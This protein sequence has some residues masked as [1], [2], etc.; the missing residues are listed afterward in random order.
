MPNKDKWCE[1]VGWF[2]FVLIVSAYLLIT[3][4][5]VEVSSIA[6]HMMN[7]VGA[8]CMIVNA[9]HKG[10]RPLLWLNIVWALVAIVGLLQLGRA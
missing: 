2:G 5:L 7:F 1:I 6:Y 4:K 9:K 3:I 10:A 8:S